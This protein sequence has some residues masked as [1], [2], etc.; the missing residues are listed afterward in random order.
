MQRLQLRHRNH[1]IAIMMIT[2]KKSFFLLIGSRRARASLDLCLNKVIE[3]WATIISARRT[4]R[5]FLPW[6]LQC[7]LAVGLGDDI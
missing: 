5:L 3:P 2:E 4:L 6:L 1:V 7:M